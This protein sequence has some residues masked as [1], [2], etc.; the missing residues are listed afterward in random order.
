MSWGIPWWAWLGGGLVVVAV[1]AVV[2][3]FLDR[4]PLSLVAAVGAVVGG[5]GIGGPFIR[6]GL[7]R[8]REQVAAR[9][10][11]GRAGTPQ[12]AGGP[13]R[14]LAP[15]RG[16]VPF[17]G[18]QNELEH[19]IAW[20]EQDVGPLRLVTGPGGVGK[21]RLASELAGRM[22]QRGWKHVWVDDG[23]E[24]SVLH[25]TAVAGEERMLLVV[26]YADTRR[27]L[28]HLLRELVTDPPARVRV[29]LLAR[30][31]GEWWDRLRGASP[32]VR[33]LLAGAHA[34]A[35]L[36]TQV[37]AFTTDQQIVDAAARAFAAELGVP[38]PESVNVMGIDGHY[39]P[40]ILDLHATGLVAVLNTVQHDPAG[41]SGSIDMSGVLEV[42]LEHEERYWISAAAAE[43]LEDHGVGVADLRD[44]VAA[45]ALLP[46]ADE[47]GA[48]QLLRR[49]GDHVTGP[50]V[51][52][53]LRSLYPPRPGRCE[54]F[55]GLQPDRLAELHL[56]SRL[57]ASPQLAAALLEDL[58]AVRAQHA[59]GVLS[60]MASD[61]YPDRD[62]RRPALEFV[63][64][65]IE[66]LDDDPDLLEHVAAVIPY[67]SQA[68]GRVR[69]DLL[70]RILTLL[71]PDDWP[72]QARVRHELGL[73]RLFLG[74]R[75]GAASM[76]SDA[77]CRYQ[78]LAGSGTGENDLNLARSLRYL[79]VAQSELGHTRE[80]LRNTIDAVTITERLAAASPGG[81]TRVGLARTLCHLGIRYHEAGF[82]EE[83]L[84]PLQRSVRLHRQHI[85]SNPPAT[86][87]PH[88]AR[89]LMN[90]SIVH[91]QLAAP[92]PALGAIEEAVQIRRRLARDN[93]DGDNVFLARA[94]A[95]A[96]ARNL[97]A[98]HPQTAAEMARESV[99][100]RKELTADNYDKHAS[101]LAISLRHLGTALRES[102]TAHQA[103]AP[104]RRAL[105]YERSMARILQ[106]VA[107][108]AAM[109]QT[110]AQ[111]GATHHAS[112]RP[113]TSMPPLRE[114]ARITYWCRTH[115]ESHEVLPVARALIRA[116]ELAS[117]TLRTAAQS[118][119]AER[120]DHE[121]DQLHY[122]IATQQPELRR[123]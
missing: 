6:H 92:G 30:S 111:L 53:W 107:A 112:G 10:A 59:V 46:P 33:A 48:A 29:L 7:Y 65:A 83:S 82:P 11:L 77:I 93:P 75:E 86:V 8:R 22:A 71:P 37:D 18:R 34:G 102:G 80:A 91:S 110:L 32:A 3:G 60:R 20:C 55:G 73:C 19:L 106:N 90:L 39:R 66:S 78:E 28:D 38:A 62:R 58:P 17:L 100:I 15:D 43:R 103:V 88:L 67:P 41:S 12:V 109:V 27:G 87:L 104:L 2:L 120:C 113:Q 4:L 101:D 25:D 13:S 81:G 117:Q 96:A 122:L 116:M 69:V 23:Q 114:A 49:L 16:V 21:S 35:D 64:T 123:D 63:V 68:L 76:L 40:R 72:A 31:A 45:T 84:E 14:L 98:G 97:D 44:I 42:L 70:W 1:A 24:T 94:L 47:G 5:A 118:E 74:H 95:E 85:K 56:L 36:P 119:I 115:A 54:P 99:E 52:R 61:F 9:A 26:D 121:V 108:R 50:H 57:R 89:A 79:G 51:M 105:A